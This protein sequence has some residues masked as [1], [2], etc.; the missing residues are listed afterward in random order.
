MKKVLFILR[1]F[2][3]SDIEWL[4]KKGCRRSVKSGTILVEEGKQIDSLFIVLD[5]IFS[6]TVKALNH[7]EIA[8]IGAGEILGEMSCVDSRPPSATVT[9]LSDSVVLAVN[10]TELTRAL[11]TDIP[12]AARF[13]HAIAVFLS[14]RLRGTMQRMGYG[15]NDKLESDIEYDDEIDLAVLD[16]VSLAGARFD[17]ILQR[18]RGQ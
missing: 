5:G 17:T 18:L 14:D 16:N 8:R 10:Q 7:R 6:I 1:E 13:Y 4:I 9:A 12:F 3:D 2:T 15:D 11:Q